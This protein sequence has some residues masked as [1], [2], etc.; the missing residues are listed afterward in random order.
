MD[1]HLNKR[2]RRRLYIAETMA[3]TKNADDQ[4]ESQLQSVKQA[5]KRISLNVNEEKSVFM[6]FK[7][8]ETIFTL[9]CKPLN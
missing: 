1:T 4:A 2:K 8:G 9:R 5:V 6:C 3:D 7:Q